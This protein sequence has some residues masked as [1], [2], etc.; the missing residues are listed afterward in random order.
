VDG[1]SSSSFRLL[2]AYVEHPRVPSGVG[3][4]LSDKPSVI[5]TSR[6]PELTGDTTSLL[7]MVPDP[8]LLTREKEKSS[9]PPPLSRFLDHSMMAAPLPPILP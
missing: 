8:L 3:W 7:P 9:A 6:A 2:D 1:A 5:L 4:K